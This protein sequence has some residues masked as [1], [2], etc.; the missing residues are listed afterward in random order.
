MLAVALAMSAEVGG[1][2]AETFGAEYDTDR[3]LAWLSENARIAAE[4]INGSTY[5]ALAEA[6]SGVPA[7]GAAARRR[8]DIDDLDAVGGVDDD[9]SD[10][11]DPLGGDS[12]LD[13]ARA[14]FAAALA[15]RIFE[16]AATRSTTV[17][18]W[19]RREAASQAGVAKKIWRTRSSNSRHSRLDG[20]EVPLGEAFSN[21]AQFPGDPSLPVSETANCR[22]ELSFSA[23]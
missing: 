7:S 5:A 12:F 15:T 10:L 1:E 19:A 4:G 9:D 2:V 6:W 18:Q 22:C 20:E 3:T 16:I 13:P 11:E 17:G 23:T 21:G 8:K 14:I